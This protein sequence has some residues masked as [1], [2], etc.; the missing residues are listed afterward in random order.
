MAHEDE[1]YLGLLD[2]A[3]YFDDSHDAYESRRPRG[4]SA[5]RLLAKADVKVNSLRAE[6]AGHALVECDIVR[7]RHTWQLGMVVAVQ[8][9]PCWPHRPGAII[10]L[11]DGTEEWHSREG[12]AYME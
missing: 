11:E 12:L 7:I 10:L 2:P 1:P 5:R 3:G 8:P 6:R 4:D 9:E